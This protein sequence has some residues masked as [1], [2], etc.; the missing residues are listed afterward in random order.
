MTST[1]TLQAWANR[2]TFRLPEAQRNPGL[3]KKRLYSTLDVACLVAVKTLTGFGLSVTAAAQI[4]QHLQNEPQTA[5]AWRRAL[6]HAPGHVYIVLA[7]GDTAARL[8]AGAAATELMPLV[9]KSLNDG[10]GAAA[11]FDVGP[12]IVR[13]MEAL[14]GRRTRHASDQREAANRLH[15]AAR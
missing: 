1:A 5:A 10:S 7:E 13:A 9:V 2:G 15:R 3:G 12:P 6:G 4:V 11:L 14:R 8:Y